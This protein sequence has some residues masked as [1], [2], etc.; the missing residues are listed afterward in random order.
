VLEAASDYLLM[1]S[2]VG[3]EEGTPFRE[4]NRTILQARSELKVAP[5]EVPIE[6]YVK[7]PDLGHGT[8]RIGVGAGWRNDRAFEE[9]NV[10]AAYHDLLDPESGYTPNA[11]IEVMSFTFRHYHHQSQVRLERF[12]PVNMISLSPMSSLSQAPS[13]KLNVGLN[14]VAYRDCQL[15]TNGYV[16]GG[17]GGAFELHLSHRESM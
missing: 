10:R 6:P 15:C 9:V 2:S 3:G 17:V 5:R 12:S 7:Q 16:N 11:Q 14:T 13:W 4:K 1:R 8:S